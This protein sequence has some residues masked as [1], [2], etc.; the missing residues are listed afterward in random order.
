[1]DIQ[2]KTVAPSFSMVTTPHPD[3]DKKIEIGMRKECEALTRIPV[4]SKIHP[5]YVKRDDTL[6]GGIHV[7]HH[8]SILWI[9]SL[10]V[11]PAFRRQGVGK[12]LLQEANLFAVQQ[13]ATEMQLNT[14]FQEAHTFFLSCGFEDVAIAPNWKYGL[15]C[16]LMRKR[17]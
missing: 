8:G 16:Y 14:Y 12:K 5:I 3:W 10:W 13:K 6:V 4:E 9:D 15:T 2:E 1:M 7:E 11:E 17:G